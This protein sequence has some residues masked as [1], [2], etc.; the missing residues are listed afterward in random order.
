MASNCRGGVSEQEEGAGREENE[1]K[2]THVFAYSPIFNI[3]EYTRL[4]NVAGYRWT[5]ER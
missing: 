2:Y 5:K 3:K 4:I 1:L